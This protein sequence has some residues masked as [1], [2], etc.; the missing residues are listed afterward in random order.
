MPTGH[1]HVKYSFMKP[2]SQSFEGLTHADV[3]NPKL[4][5]KM[6]QNCIS[7]TNGDRKMKIKSKRNVEERYS[8]L[9]LFSRNLE[10]AAPC[11]DVIVSKLNQKD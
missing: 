10:I 4:A 5:Q 3:I 9:K 11:C 6:A 2:L 7:C 8:F 1:L